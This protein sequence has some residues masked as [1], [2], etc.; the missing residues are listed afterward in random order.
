MS[1]PSAFIQPN[2]PGYQ[3]PTLAEQGVVEDSAME[4]KDS[5]ITSLELPGPENPLLRERKTAGKVEETD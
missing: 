2:D 3:A 1:P 5:G 4:V